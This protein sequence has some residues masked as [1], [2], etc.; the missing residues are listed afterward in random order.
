MGEFAEQMIDHLIFGDP[1]D[2][3]Y[4]EEE[5]KNLQDFAADSLASA[6]RDNKTKDLNKGVIEW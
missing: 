6:K 2:E 5:R 4:E 1:W 3:E